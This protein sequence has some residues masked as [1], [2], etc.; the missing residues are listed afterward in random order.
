LAEIGEF[1]FD[2]FVIGAMAKD[3][4]GGFHAGEHMLEFRNGGRGLELE[5]EFES[6]AFFGHERGGALVE[7]GG[8][9]GAD[10]SKS[11]RCHITLGVEAAAEFGDDGEDDVD[12]FVKFGAA[13]F[14]GFDD[15]HFV[16]FELGPEAIRAFFEFADALGELLVGDLELGVGRLGGLAAEAVAEVHH[17][18][19]NGGEGGEAEHPIGE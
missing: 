1:G 13:I 11:N 8:D 5:V 4:A 9:A 3:L 19:K 12:A 18:F 10:R 15:F 2:A 14:A 6:E 17:I 7:D 16:G